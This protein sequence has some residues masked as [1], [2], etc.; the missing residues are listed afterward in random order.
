M[1]KVL[2]P[3]SISIFNCFFYNIKWFLNYKTILHVN[4]V[5]AFSVTVFLLKLYNKASIARVLCSKV[6]WNNIYL[7]D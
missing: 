5:K 6:I 3:N 7:H 2:V 1:L 4:H